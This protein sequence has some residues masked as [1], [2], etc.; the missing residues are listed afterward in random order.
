LFKSASVG[1]S[2]FI[3]SAISARLAGVAVIL[4]AM[5]FMISSLSFLYLIALLSAY[6]SYNLILYD[7]RQNVNGCPLLFS[8]YALR[9]VMQAKK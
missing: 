3:R 5:A 2:C 7:N 1:A 4:C 6:L 8:V 9:N